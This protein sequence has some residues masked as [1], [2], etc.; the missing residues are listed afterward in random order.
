V[1]LDSLRNEGYL[2][3]WQRL[4]F[5]SSGVSKIGLFRDLMVCGSWRCGVMCQ[6]PKD[7]Y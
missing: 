1:A 4:Q 6:W 3:F 5:P 2:F 7:Y